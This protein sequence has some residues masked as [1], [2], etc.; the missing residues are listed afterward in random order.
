ME[1]EIFVIVLVLVLG[2]VLVLV[3]GGGKMCADRFADRTADRNLIFEEPVLFQP[4][5]NPLI[6]GEPIF[7]APFGLAYSMSGR[8]YREGFPGP[9]RPRYD[10]SWGGRFR[11]G[12][13]NFFGPG[14]IPGDEYGPLPPS[15]H[16]FGGRCDCHYTSGHIKYSGGK[17]YRPWGPKV[18]PRDSCYDLRNF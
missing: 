3:I 18:D 4:N 8:P 17:C 6:R 9:Y 1:N 10:P 12:P 7:Q 2:I 14:V 5:A 13:V 16:P 11:H 15:S